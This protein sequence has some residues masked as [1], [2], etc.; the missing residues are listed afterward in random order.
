MGK[1]TFLS[2]FMYLTFSVMEKKIRNLKILSGQKLKIE[3]G[4]FSY[5]QVVYYWKIWINKSNCCTLW[6]WLWKKETGRDLKLLENSCI[7]QE[8]GNGWFWVCWC[9]YQ[10]TNGAWA[11]NGEFVWVCTCFNHCWSERRWGDAFTVLELISFTWQD[12]HKN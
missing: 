11:A 7:K 10:D 1:K 5:M 12:L 2:M 3:V 4:S 6:C 9:A 8:A